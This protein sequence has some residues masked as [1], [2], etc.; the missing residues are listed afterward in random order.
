MEENEPNKKITYLLLTFPKLSTTFIDREILALRRM[1]AAVKIVALLRP[2]GPLSAYQRDLQ[3]ETRYIYPARWTTMVAAHLHYLVSHPRRYFSTLFYL[4]TR[5]HP[6]F[7]SH[8]RTLLHFFQGVDVTYALRRE[9]GD[10]IHAHF[11]NQSATIALV[12]GRLLNIPYSVTVHASGELYANPF[13][14]REK[15]AGA[16][17]IATCTEYNRDYLSRL[18]ENLFDQKLL[19]N[20]HCLDTDLFQRRHTLPQEPRVILSVGQLMERKGLI[21]LVRACRIL[22]DCN[23]RFT[24]RIVGEGPQRKAL[25]DEIKRLGLSQEIELAGALPQ[26]ELIHQY[27]QS[28]IFTLPAVEAE[29]GDRDGIPNVILEA[30]AME[31]PVVSTWHSGLPEV[32]RDQENGLL[33]PPRQPAS[34]AE[35]LLF[36]LKDTETARAIGL[37]GRRTVL[38]KFNPQRNIQKLVDAFMA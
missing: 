21:Y 36:L 17:F 13:M 5:E 35:A 37:Q 15:M 19:V 28:S 20:Y 25:E 2:N 10:H 11:L 7:L 34:L 22:K 3:R 33:V 29:N 24:C 9:P 31:L 16:K 38:D 4:L 6:T 30:M 18:S 27:E 26:E 8:R 23:A 1:G 12:A 32:I 14:V